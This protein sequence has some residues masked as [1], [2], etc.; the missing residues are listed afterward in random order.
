MQLSLLI[1]N[2]GIQSVTLPGMINRS[3]RRIFSYFS[4]FLLTT[5]IMA[6]IEAPVT[7]EARIEQEQ[8]RAGEVL[9]VLITATS[10]PDFKIYAVNDIAEGPIP[11]EVIIEGDMVDV[12]GETREPP[13][14]NKYDEGFMR[15]TYFHDGTVTFETGVRIK[16]N[17]DPGDYTLSAGLLFQACDPTICFPPTTKTF[18]L[19]DRKSVV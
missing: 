8:I 17:L 15:E 18:D 3:L 19:T 11:S 13:P 6:Q 14:T 10:E 1:H 16:E 9:T 7:V 4:I 2:S 5:G 12:V